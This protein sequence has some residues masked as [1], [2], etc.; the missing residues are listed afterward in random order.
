MEGGNEG[1]AGQPPQ[2][3]HAARHPPPRGSQARLGPSPVLLPRPPHQ[4][5]GQTEDLTS[6]SKTTT[7]F[8]TPLW[9]WVGGY[10]GGR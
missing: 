6:V 2:G 10:G 1:D 3:R 9:A 4:A 7:C 8:Q 5:S